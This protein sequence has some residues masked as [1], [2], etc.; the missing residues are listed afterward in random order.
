VVVQARRDG[1]LFTFKGTATMGG[2]QVLGCGRK[3]TTSYSVGL[4]TRALKNRR[5]HQLLET[6]YEGRPIP[7]GG[8][9]ETDVPSWPHSG[10]GGA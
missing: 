10:A 4:A 6:I 3:P 5:R 2:E 7:T 9:G 8:T 1:G